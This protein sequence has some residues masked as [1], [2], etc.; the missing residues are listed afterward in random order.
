MPVVEQTRVV[1]F[2][3][4]QMFDLVTDVKHYPEFLPWCVAARIRE[5]SEAHMIADLVI[6]FQ[7]IRE[8][9]TSDVRFDRAALRV[10]TAL[11]DGPFRH[12]TN[13]WR[14]RDVPDGKGCEIEIHVDFA[15]RSA[16]LQR[17]IE[18]LFEEAQKRMIGAF[19]KRARAL[20]GA[21]GGA[22]EGAA[23]SSASSTSPKASA[24]V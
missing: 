6:G 3:A 18:P 1:P 2:R 17:L 19:E 4:E 16:L 13:K 10:D 24:T 15:F 8:R 9:F 23:G 20:Y 5:Q 22:A 7:V 14:F 21:A 12:L 11:V